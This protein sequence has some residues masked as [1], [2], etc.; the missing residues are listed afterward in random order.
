MAA[1]DVVDWSKIHELGT[2]L[3]EE[4]IRPAASG[5]MVFKS[6]GIGLADVALAARAYDK[7]R[8]AV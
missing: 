4:A 6:V 3:A 1:T 5:V 8:E 7:S 2:L